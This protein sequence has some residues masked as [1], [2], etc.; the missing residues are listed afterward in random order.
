MNPPAN[1]FGN[2]PIAV[3]RCM[4]DKKILGVHTEMFSEGLLDLY[5]CGALTNR[6]KT[7]WRDKFVADCALGSQRLY[8]IF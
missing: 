2:I 5:E 1:R 7:L 3:T 8:D 4:T 6:K